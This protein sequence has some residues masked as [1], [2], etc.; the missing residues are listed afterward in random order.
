MDSS[1]NNTTNKFTNKITQ[2][3]NKLPVNKIQKKQNQIKSE[4][5]STYKQNKIRK[6]ITKLKI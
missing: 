1:T 5:N 6:L 3:I 2:Q 4:N